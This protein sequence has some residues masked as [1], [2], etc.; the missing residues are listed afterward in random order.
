MHLYKPLSAGRNPGNADNGDADKYWV[1]ALSHTVLS[2]F[3][4]SYIAI[5]ASNLQMEIAGGNEPMVPDHSFSFS[6]FLPG[7]V[8]GQGLS[9]PE[10]A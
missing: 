3:N 4:D 1:N 10:S 2:T 7:C 6:A 8:R 9:P 5:E